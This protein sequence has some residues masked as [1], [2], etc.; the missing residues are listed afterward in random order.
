MCG[1][2]DLFF[3]KIAYDE[4]TCNQI[5]CK[6]MNLIAL[7]YPE[8]Y[9]AIKALV[10]RDTE[11]EY[12]GEHPL[13]DECCQ[14]CCENDCKASHGHLPRC[15][16]YYTKHSHHKHTQHDHWS[17]HH[18]LPVV[19]F[20]GAAHFLRWWCQTHLKGNFLPNLKKQIY[21]YFCF[22]NHI[23]GVPSGEFADVLHIKPRF[24]SLKLEVYL[25]FL[26]NPRH[27]FA[28]K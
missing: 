14:V 26:Q 21:F 18:V 8:K 24:T 11:G 2:R 19:G 15:S 6:E 7:T 23:R 16:D 9:E 10:Q 20:I 5:T 25:Y 17:F 27:Y 22:L 3:D 12:Y 13:I 28:I 1:S 4:Q